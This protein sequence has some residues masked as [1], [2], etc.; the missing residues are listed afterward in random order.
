[1]QA[2]QCKG[3]RRFPIKK[4]ILRPPPF[5]NPLTDRYGPLD[6]FA[7]LTAQMTHVVRGRFF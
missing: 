3:R 5:K 1:M 7:H 2:R 4:A 6:Q